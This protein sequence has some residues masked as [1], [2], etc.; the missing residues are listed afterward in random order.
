MLELIMLSAPVS[1]KG[2]WILIGILIAQLHFHVSF[3]LRQ[4]HWELET[5]STPHAKH[6]N[7]SGKLDHLQGQQVERA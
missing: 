2:P 6:R 3:D 4:S 7:R 5:P 1:Q